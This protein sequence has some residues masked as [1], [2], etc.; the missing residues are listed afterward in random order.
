LGVAL[1]RGEEKSTPHSQEC[2]AENRTVYAEVH[3]GPKTLCQT[4]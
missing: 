2:Q 3:L 4:T 1:L